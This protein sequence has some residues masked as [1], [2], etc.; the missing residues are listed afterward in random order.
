M[1]LHLLFMSMPQPGH[2]FPNL[3]VIEE[4]VREGHRVS[5]VTGASVAD[6]VGAAGA[7]AVSYD[8]LF[9]RPEQLEGGTEGADMALVAHADGLVMLATAESRLTDDR[10]V[11]VLYD[12]MTAQ[13]GRV[14]AEKWGLPS[15]QLNPMFASNEKF[16]MMRA[17]FT[18]EESDAPVDNTESVAAAMPPEMQQWF[19][20]TTAMLVD[21]G[22]DTP[23]G[24]WIARV[25][26]FGVVY[27]PQAF[28]YAGELFDE[29]FAFV[30]PCISERAFLGSWQAPDTEL[31][32]VLVSLG[33]VVNDRPEFFKTVV[34]AFTG[35]PFHVVITV[36]KGVDPA[37]LGPL[38]ENIEVH[39]FVPHLAVLE[40]ASVCVTH[41]GMGGVLE[42]LTQAVP[43]V[44]VPQTYASAAIVH[45][46]RQLGLAQVLDA[47][48]FTP[49]SLRKAVEETAAD[50]TIRKSVQDMQ[51][52]IQQAGGARRAVR[53]IENYLRR[54]LD[55]TGAARP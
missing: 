45:R 50:D 16:N 39:A 31:P 1:S 43:M 53:E 15:I 37:V 11:A 35:A 46:V 49:E 18:Q 27:L 28:Q 24:E 10:P 5:F 4:L 51:G 3:A 40:H 55:P 34:E 7:T 25:P 21:N 8:S 47:A 9:D 13:V 32:V 48:D 23:V 41:G 6:A 30:G 14:L 2:V 52:H 38:P 20:K 36:G 22:I 42:A 17:M 33:T 12:T 26:D 19:A 29:R 54:V 44:V